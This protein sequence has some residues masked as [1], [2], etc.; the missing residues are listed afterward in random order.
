MLSCVP[1]VSDPTTCRDVCVRKNGSKTTVCMCVC[2]GVSEPCP[3]TQRETNRQHTDKQRT[4]SSPLKREAAMAK[5]STSHLRTAGTSAGLVGLTFSRTKACFVVG[6]GGFGV[7]VEGEGKGQW[8]SA[9]EFERGSPPFSF[10]Q[11]I[12][13]HTYLSIHLHVCIHLSLPLS[14]HEHTWKASSSTF[15]VHTL[16]QRTN[17]PTDPPYLSYVTY[18]HLHQR[19][20]NPCLAC[21]DINLHL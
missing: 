9:H 13:S 14:P 1:E 4:S 5:T 6:V 18:I 17:L 15:L 16:S 10:L 8:M 2:V 12:T 19:T 7:C 20:S 11:P 21:T 3:S